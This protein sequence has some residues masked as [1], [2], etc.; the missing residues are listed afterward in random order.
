[1]EKGIRE[2]AFFYLLRIS[3]QNGGA[4]GLKSIVYG[5]NQ[6]VISCLFFNSID[7]E[8]ALMLSTLAFLQ[9]KSMHEPFI[10][11]LLLTVDY[12]Q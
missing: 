3:P 5:Q 12:R 8:S 6:R 1:M 10:D 4:F 2:F 7:A 11:S 9:V